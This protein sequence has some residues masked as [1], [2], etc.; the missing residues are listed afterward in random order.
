MTQMMTDWFYWTM[1]LLFMHSV[2]DLA[3]QGDH[4]G[5]RKARRIPYEDPITGRYKTVWPYYLFGHGLL[6]GAGVWFV[7]QSVTLGLLET[8]CHTLSD[9]LSCERRITLF[10]DQAIHATC[11]IVWAWMFIN[12][13]LL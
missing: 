7:T 11:K 2:T 5:R 12:W 8:A 3:L 4:I 1:A 9:Y 10:Q 6:N 13:S